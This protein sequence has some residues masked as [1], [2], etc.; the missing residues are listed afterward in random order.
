MPAGEK[1]RDEVFTDLVTEHQ[2]RLYG[3]IF[4]MVQ[5]SADTEDLVQ[6]TLITLWRRFDQF[7]LGTDF[8]AWSLTTARYE[9]LNFQRAGRRP[10]LFTE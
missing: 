7:E 10:N 9:V 4:A 6:R 3:Y 1:H 8:C 5:N 2:A